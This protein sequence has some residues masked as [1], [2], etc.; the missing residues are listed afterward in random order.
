MAAELSDDVKDIGNSLAYNVLENLCKDGV[1]SKAQVDLY[2]T[3]YAKLHEFVLQTYENEKS[4]LKRAKDLT[5][6]LMSEKI[7]LE[8]T[9]MDQAEDAQI[10]SGLKNEF[11]KME[12]QYSVISERQIN[13]EMTVTELEQE[14]QELQQAYEIRQAEIEEMSAPIMNALNSEIDSIEGEIEFMKSETERNEVMLEELKARQTEAD[15]DLDT[16]TLII[17]QLENEYS[18]LERDPDR[19]RKQS[20]KFEQAIKALTITQDERL[21]ELDAIKKRLAQLEEAQ[22]EKKKLRYD[23]QYR[24]NMIT[25]S[26]KLAQDG[27]DEAQKKLDRRLNEEAMERQK[28]V[29][30]DVELKH[31]GHE[32]FSATDDVTQQEKKVAKMLRIVKQKENLKG[33]LKE[34]IPPFEIERKEL[35]KK[36]KQLE[37]D[38]VRQQKLLVDIQAEVDLFIG[39]YLKQET[40]DKE[41]KEAYDVVVS[42]IDECQK[43]LKDL[44]QQEVLANNHLKLVSSQREKIARDASTAYRLCRE[45]EG[46]VQMKELEEFDLKKKL[47][48]I[49]QRQKEFCS[50]YEVV[51]NERNK[52]VAMI[53]SSSQD[54]SEKKERLKILQSEVEIL[55]MESVGKEKALQKTKTEH[56]IQCVV[57][58]K[59]RCDFVEIKAKCDVLNEQVEQYIIEIDK[60]NSIIKH[61]EKEMVLLRRK[62]EIAMETRNFTGIQLID[63]NDELCILW[64]KSNIQ[65]KILKKGEE[66]MRAKQED[67]RV[68]KI[69]L[70][71]VQ[72]QLQVVQKRIPDVP[73]LQEETIRLGEALAATKASSE[74]L[75]R[76]LENPA[77]GVRKWRELGGEDLDSET[78]AAKI[79]FHEDR[80]NAKKEQLLE[81]EL[82]LEE[83]SVLSDK[84]RQQAVDG[85]KGTLELSQKV[86]I[87]QSR[88]KD[89]TRNMMATVSELS[90]YQATAM[91]SQNDRDQVMNKVFQ[92]KENIENG[93]APWEGLEAELQRTLQVEQ[94]QALDLQNAKQRKQEEAIL[95]S[96]A[97]RTTAEPRVN[98]YIP[99]GEYGLPKAY[100]NHAPFMPVTLGTN[101]RHI[102]KPNPKAI[103]A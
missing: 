6:Q 14:K 78:L 12:E 16:N 8:K 40:L 65:E 95:H 60:L 4:F 89:I 66:T 91:K 11:S 43:T 54:L 39:A 20:E 84:L 73:K 67:I 101:M 51:K 44:K 56:Q 102:R 37:E 61:I 45:T 33:H 81:K 90:M 62:N 52:Y 7:K 5:Q 29:K 96:T 21:L 71:E 99:E 79:N 13:L 30:M 18:K 15:E 28:R 69:Q 49:Q 47:M 88:I 42:E 70:A 26:V 55:R 87:F 100:G 41:K 63:R 80:L 59:L 25:E 32:F 93:L 38:S 57:R 98:A 74:V 77:N 92:A 1:I 86:N 35:I 27:C 58:D 64:E 23:G 22:K 3:K 36:R 97:T 10:Y 50:M 24:L 85:R 19:Y 103:E 31:L 72:R 75:S 34:T 53:Q 68:L 76:E 48:E 17:G 9:T 83:V 46:E 2:K 94:Q 82:I